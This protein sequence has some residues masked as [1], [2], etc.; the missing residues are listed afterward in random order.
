[1]SDRIVITGAGGQVGSFLARRAAARNHDVLALTSAQWDITD[2][3]AGPELGGGDVV[4]NCAAYT[5]V[6]AAESHPDTAHAVNATGAGHVAAACAAAGARLVHIS[7]DYVFGGAAGRAR[8]YEP[9]DPTDPVNVYGQSKLAGERAVLATLPGAT[10][11]R[12]AWVYT[13]SGADF[14][15]V[16]A[17]KAHAGE[18]V[19]VV[20]DQVGSPTYVGDLVDALLQI[21]DRGVTATVDAAVVHA[22]N[23]GPASRYDQ[24][25]AV[26]AALGVDEGLVR[27]VDSAAAP[28]PARRPGYSVLGAQ[29]S[30][31]AGVTPLRPWRE[32]IAAALAEQ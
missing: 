28:R 5:N 31:Q 6:D 12:T 13:G 27:P 16:M 9:D 10:V 11:V 21:V 26:Y 4:V 3:T 17:R 23:A 29:R 1:M 7:T 15:A 14:V 22:A 20:S 32:A 18:P 2:P 24:A 30:A 25:R 19:D 8:P